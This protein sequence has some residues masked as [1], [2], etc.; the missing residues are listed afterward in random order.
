[1][2]SGAGGVY[3]GLEIRGGQTDEVTVVPGSMACQYKG[4]KK[5]EKTYR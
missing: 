2:G 3:V 4:V 1:M 5:L